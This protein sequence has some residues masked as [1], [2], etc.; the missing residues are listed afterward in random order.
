MTVPADHIAPVEDNLLS[1]VNKARVAG[2]RWLVDA[3]GPHVLALSS[4]V[5]F[6]M[7]NLVAG[8][9]FEPDEAGDEVREI[10]AGYVERGLPWMWWTTPSYTS[11]RLEDALLAVG[12]RREETPGMYTDL[13]DVPPAP[14]DVEIVA[15]ALEDPDFVRTLIDGFGIPDFVLSPMRALLGVFDDEQ[16]SFLVRRGGNPA[17]VASGFISGETLGVYNVTTL[18]G[19]RGHGVGTAATA[20]VMRAG[21]ERGCTHAILHTTTMGRPV[22]ERLGF[23]VVCPTTQ[24]IWTPGEETRDRSVGSG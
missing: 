15:D 17:G 10:A 19:E 23:R 14:P 22:Y 12:L 5:P 2:L 8:A 7:F 4:H 24:W 9:R 13:G 21:R 18:P 6:P 1:W 3:S 16:I 20:A 11:P